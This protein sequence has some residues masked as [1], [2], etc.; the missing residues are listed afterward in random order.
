MLPSVRKITAVNIISVLSRSMTGDDDGYFLRERLV[1]VNAL[2]TFF[3]VLNGFTDQPV[4]V[5][6]LFRVAVG[7]I[8][9]TPYQVNFVNYPCAFFEEKVIEAVPGFVVPTM[10]HGC[11]FPSV[12]YSRGNGASFRLIRMVVR[13]LLA[14][15]S[16]S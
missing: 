14:C 2:I 6:L 16:R 10:T 3:P 13:P 4:L 9:T 1:K 12:T 7:A 5:R 11:S 15:P 8:V